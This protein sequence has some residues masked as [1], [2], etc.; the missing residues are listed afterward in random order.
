MRFA[1]PLIALAA[2]AAPVLAAPLDAEQIITVR[3]AYDDLD[4]T[5][6]EGRA[7]LEAR[8]NAKVRKA[9]TVEGIARYSNGRSKLDDNCIAEARSTARVEIDRL[10]AAE[11]RRGRAIA[12]N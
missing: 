6:A 2:V 9:C 4:L 5:S 7:T 1:L 12:A 10:A 11:A 3:V 8:I